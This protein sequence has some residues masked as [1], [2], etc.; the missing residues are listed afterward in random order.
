[1]P[2][3]AAGMGVRTSPPAAVLAL[4]SLRA[5]YPREYR[6]NHASAIHNDDYD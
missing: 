6:E 1:M 2:S 5:L 4:R 3:L